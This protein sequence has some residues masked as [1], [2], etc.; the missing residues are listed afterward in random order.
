MKICNEYLN[1]NFFMFW[2]VECIIYFASDYFK[3]PGRA[4]LF[5]KINLKRMVTSRVEHPIFSRKI[6]KDAETSCAFCW[7]PR[8][9]EFNTI[10]LSS[11]VHDPPFFSFLP[12]RKDTGL[13]DQ[14]LPH[15]WKLC[16][17]VKYGCEYVCL[18]MKKYAWKQTKV[19]LAF[20][21][22]SSYHNIHVNLHLLSRN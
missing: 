5:A 21:F 6:N 17:N 12:V 13:A 20:C 10:D 1:V 3:T 14:L 11:S 18:N 16:K 4:C 7:F 15:M 19:L 2:R 9:R 22:Q 8:C